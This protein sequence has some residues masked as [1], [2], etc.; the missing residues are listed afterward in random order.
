MTALIHTIGARGLI[1]REVDAERD[2]QDTQWG[3]ASHDDEHQG[4]DFV[5]FVRE[6]TDRARHAVNTGALDEF[7]AQ[8][9]EIA[10]LAVAAVESLDRKRI[11]DLLTRKA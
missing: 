7:R 10:A 2:R 11:A 4:S 8:L 1:Y 6:H 5:R 9:I 3:G